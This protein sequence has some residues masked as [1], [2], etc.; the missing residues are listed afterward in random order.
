MSCNQRQANTNINST[1]T[2][3]TARQV[4]IF[5]DSDNTFLTAQSFNRKLDWLKIR[6]YLANP[7]EGRELIEMV[8]FVGLPPARE[9]FEEQRKTKE[10]FIYWAKNSGFLVVTKEG[11]TKGEEYENNIDIVMAMDA[12]ELALEVRPDIV[13][14][15][16]GD[17]DFAYLAEKLRR[18]GMRVEVASVEQS[19]GNE[20]KNAASSTI[21]LIE[22][23]DSFEQQ[24]NNQTYYRIGNANI[25]D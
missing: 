18:R 12:L 19:L 2:M 7:A 25:F 10:K 5:A 1:Q 23:F 9:R 15:V 17:S 4:M 3:V 21:D 22:I 11:K 20:L 16:T 13:V 6:D 14:L 24:N 8:L